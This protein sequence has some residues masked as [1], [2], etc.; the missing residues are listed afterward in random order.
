MSI[1]TVTQEIVKLDFFYRS[2]YPGNC[3]DG[4]EKI[5]T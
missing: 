5:V 2:D 3:S 4:K 1:I